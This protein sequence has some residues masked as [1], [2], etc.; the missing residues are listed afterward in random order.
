MHKAVA[1]LVA[2]VPPAED[3]TLRLAMVVGVSRAAFE[4]VERAR[5]A[6]DGGALR[7]RCPDGAPLIS[8]MRREYVDAGWELSDWAT[9]IL[10]RPIDDANPVPPVNPEALVLADTP[11]AVITPPR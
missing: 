11:A 4:L 8:D 7:F 9:H 3:A 10:A 1:I 5:S 2:D 6:A